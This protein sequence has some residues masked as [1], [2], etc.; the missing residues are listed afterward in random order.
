MGLISWGH[1][2]LT[3]IFFLLSGCLLYLGYFLGI[4]SAWVI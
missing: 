1:V 2:K 4:R 3:G